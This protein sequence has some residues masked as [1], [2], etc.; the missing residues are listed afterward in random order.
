MNSKTWVMTLAASSVLF[1]GNVLAGEI[2]KYTDADGM[3]SYVDRPTTNPNRENVDIISRPTDNAAIQA[4][5]QARLAASSQKAQEPAAGGKELT[6]SERREAAAA[7][8]QACDQHRA[9]LNGIAAARR[10]YR[11]D[12]NG[13]RVYLNDEQS[14]A[15]R[16]ELQQLVEE[17]CS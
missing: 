6:R 17:T 4:N 11:E 16:D 7:K 12:E 2:Y 5:A 3:V 1:A 15:A 10:L 14:Q 9:Q 13:E 8:Q